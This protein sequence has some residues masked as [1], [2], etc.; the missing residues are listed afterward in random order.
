LRGPCA[1]LLP[2]AP[3]QREAR[4]RGHGHHPCRWIGCSTALKSARRFRES[5]YHCNDSPTTDDAG[6]GLKCFHPSNGRLERAAHAMSRFGV[7]ARGRVRSRLALGDA[8]TALP[9]CD[10]ED[11]DMHAIDQ[12]NAA[13]VRLGALLAFSPSAVTLQR[14]VTD[15]QLAGVSP[16]EIVRC[17]VN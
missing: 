12:R 17:V 16:D 5:E 13:L 14:A 4:S 11:L 3:L 15:A 6:V 7:L 10:L 8:V 9:A 2:G 1:L